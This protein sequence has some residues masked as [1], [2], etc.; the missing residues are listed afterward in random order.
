[1]DL[2]DKIRGGDA[3]VGVIG[4][5][6]VGLPLAL[7]AAE[8]GF[9]VTGFEIDAEKTTA[10][11][12]GQSYIGHIAVA[13]VKRAREAGHPI[14]A[15]THLADFLPGTLEAALNLIRDVEADICVLTGDFRRRV[16]GP[17]DDILP[18]MAQ[19]A[20]QVK[21]SHGTYAVLGNHD[22]ATKVEPFEDLGI[23]LLVNETHTIQKG[24]AKLQLTGT[25]DVHYYYTEEAREALATTPDGF[26]IALIH[27]A[28]FA[29]AAAENGYH[30]QAIPAGARSV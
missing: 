10:L 26:K 21:A 11:N 18:A 3:R 16:T 12:A 13:V 1:M 8:A 29:D 28:E 5:G 17:F 15:F 14:S 23:R 19:L 25:D 7:T 20:S 9:P 22:S 24:S 30:L 27:S 6:Y 4:L 2:T